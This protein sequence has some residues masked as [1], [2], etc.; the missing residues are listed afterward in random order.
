MEALVYIILHLKLNFYVFVPGINDP[1]ASYDG[2]PL[3]SAREVSQRV[4]VDV[5]RP[6]KKITVAFTLWAQFLAY[7]L[8][9]T[10]VSLG[11]LKT[12][13]H[14]VSTLFISF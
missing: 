10:G 4:H 2:G 14:F 5:N 8:S 13:V 9:Q 12:V 7:D 3:P 11:E 1:R 6:S